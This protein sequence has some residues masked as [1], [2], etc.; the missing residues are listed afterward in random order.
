MSMLDSTVT[1]VALPTIMNVFG[2]SMTGIQWVT[3]AYTLSMAVVVPLG[4]YLSR[5]FG[6]ERVFLA[7][8]FVFTICSFLCGVS[9]SLNTLILFR[10]LQALGGGIM[11]PIGMAM[12]L[13]LFPP[14]K[15]GLAMGVFGVAMTAAPAFG[16]TLGGYIVD[17]LGWEYVFYVN[18]PIG[19]IAVM[20]AFVFFEFAPRQPFPRFDIPGFISSAIGSSFILY[21]LGKSESI[22]WT[23]P[24]Y[25]YMTIVGVGALIFFVAN[26]IVSDN[27]LLDLRILKYRNYTVSMILVIVQQLMM[28]GVIY[29]TPIFLQN[30]RGLNALQSG[31]VLLPSSLV[32][33]AL[34]P[35]AGKL[36]DIAGQR[37]TKWLIGSGVAISG[38]FTF[39]LSSKLTLD[40]SIMDIII[41]NS[42]RNIG[43]G[44]SMMPVMTLGLFSIPVAD[45]Q[46]A[47]ALQRFIQQ[48]SASMVIAAVTY[49]IT[50][51][52]NANYAGAVAQ[53]TPSNVPLSDT[54][55][56]LSGMLVQQ[57]MAAADAT[58]QAL[59]L[60]VTRI[61]Q[62]NYV[63]AMQFTIFLTALVGTCALLLVPF[64]KVDKRQQALNAMPVPAAHSPAPRRATAEASADR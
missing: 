9:W 24:T 64:F 20:M 15:R 54:L 50:T 33:A 60:I 56:A 13:A 62:E 34:M 37:G 21:L 30:F 63:L 7:A 19:I 10:I 49:S 44:I 1:S 39:I 11:M 25:I 35:I 32:M 41:L 31:Q 18:V 52:F 26:E 38:T 53:L 29:T 22:D 12:V 8:L 27:P 51:K 42:I 2:V 46:K 3:T 43:L 55:R 28:V 47:T 6:A 45:A 58:Q 17:S 57:G 36:T 59:T 48:I 4:P 23:D 14:S 16:P 5:V 40:A 61:Y